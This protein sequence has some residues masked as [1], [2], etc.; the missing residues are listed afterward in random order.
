MDKGH[1]NWRHVLEQSGWCAFNRNQT[2][3]SPKIP[4]IAKVLNI[5]RLRHD[6]LKTVHQSKA[7]PNTLSSRYG[8]NEFPL[9]T[10]FALDSNP[11]RYLI[12]CAPRSREAQTVISSS[13]NISNTLKSRAI[14]LV[15]DPRNRRYV[16]FEKTALSGKFIQF[17]PSIYLPQNT[18]AE[19]LMALIEQND[20]LETV[21]WKQCHRVIIDNWKCL[22]GRRASSVGSNGFIRRIVGWVSA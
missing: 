12:L 4:E 9:H 2:E 10:D 6:K 18:E 11:P 15:Q 14:F 19:T 16:T 13:S 3:F 21:D 7:R 8:T 20:N 5:T 17:N 22:H 1:E